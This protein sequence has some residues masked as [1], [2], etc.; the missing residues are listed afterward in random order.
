M[1]A[2]SAAFFLLPPF[3][4]GGRVGTIYVTTSSHP[5]A[6]SSQE[7]DA[8]VVGCVCA[9]AGK[10]PPPCR[11]SITSLSCR[12]RRAADLVVPDIKN[13]FVC[14]PMRCVGAGLP[15]P[16]RLSRQQPPRDRN[17]R[18][19]RS[20]STLGTVSRSDSPLIFPGLDCLPQCVPLPEF[21]GI[22]AAGN[23][24]HQTRF[25]QFLDRQFVR[26]DKH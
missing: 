21:D 3:P 2:S 25:P 22:V 1:N 20:G 23:R 19:F 8:I 10:P 12:S 15:P 7:R 6:R 18:L 24:I 11:R 17:V 13:A 4:G 14:R 16:P 9:R 5:A 26:P